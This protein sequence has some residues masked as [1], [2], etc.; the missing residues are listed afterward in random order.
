MD[1]CDIYV[2][3]IVEEGVLVMV[4]QEGV[5]LMVRDGRK[6]GMSEEIIKRWICKY[7]EPQLLLIWL[8]I[9]IDMYSTYGTFKSAFIGVI[10]FV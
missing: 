10:A 1:W 2:A 9:I 6:K 4:D 3:Q 8:S 7:Y 5:L